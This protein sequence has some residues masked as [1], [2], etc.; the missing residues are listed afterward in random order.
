MLK[1]RAALKAD[2]L[3]EIRQIPETF[4][5]TGIALKQRHAI[6][7]GKPYV[8]PDLPLALTA[9]KGNIAFIDFE[10]LQTAVPKLDGFG[11]WAQ[12]VFQVSCHVTDTKGEILKHNEWLADETHLSEDLML[13]AAAKAI[14]DSCVG[15]D[16]VVS[17]NMAFESARIKE[18]AD[19]VPSQK[20]E[21]LNVTARMID[22]LDTV[23][24]NYYHQD[25][26]GSLSIKS[27]LPVMV[28]SMA[29]EGMAVA[30]GTDAIEAAREMLFGG[31][32]KDLVDEIRANLLAYCGQ[33][34]LA[35]V[36]IFKKLQEIAKA[37]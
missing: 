24:D 9:Y 23:Q 37:V 17:Y 8:S 2:N 10:T 6:V 21:L 20:E 12:I 26:R 15:C 29:Y 34:T 14:I 32:S 1:T 22:L 5:L 35:M 3:T 31:H 11:P 30:N 19:R 16:T 28:P 25:F 27:V 36:E 33:D 13:K 18:L 4:P 7:K